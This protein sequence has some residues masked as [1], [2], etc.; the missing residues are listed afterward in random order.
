MMPA[1]RPLTIVMYHYVRDLERSRFPAIKGLS[2]ER[3]CRQLDFIQSRYTPVTVQDLF[4]AQASSE[5]ELP[6][7]P[8]LLTFDD[9]YSDHFANVFPLLDARGI[10]GCFFPPAQAILEHR[11]L[12]VNKIQ[13]VL[14]SVPDVE[15]LLDQV[16][17][18]L[19]EFRSEYALKTKEA[20]LLA[21]TE[22]HRYDRREVIVLKRLLQR[23]LPEP[24]RVELVQRLFAEHVTSDETAFACEL[25]M[26]VDQ[27]ACLQRHGMHIGSHGYSHAW[28]NHISPQAQ[29]ME[30][31]RSLA[32]LQKFDLRDE[33]TMCYPYGGFNESLLEILRARHCR[34]GFTVEAR[35]ANLDTDDPLTL[36]RIDTNDL[37]S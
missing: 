23:E 32:F 1:N 36:P 3:F 4:A 21:F 25:Y 24:V 13:F 20:Y 31:D 30:V 37:P 18:S 15:A 5:M 34:L 27:I 10:Q 19:A 22:E 35:L 12:D 28:L 6:P 33:W 7:D 16:F 26:S 11:V 14:A 17:S 9:G 29:A 2:V 8:I